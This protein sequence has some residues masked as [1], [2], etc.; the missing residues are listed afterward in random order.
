MQKDT[1]LPREIK[2]LKKQTTKIEHAKRRFIEEKFKND[3]LEGCFGDFT[4]TSAKIFCKR[5]ERYS[6]SEVKRII[7]NLKEKYPEFFGV[8][9][10][11]GLTVYVWEMA[12]ENEIILL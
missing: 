10:D 7:E 5:T 9:T 8:S 3:K 12:K 6:F 2:T 11:G 4:Y 1:G